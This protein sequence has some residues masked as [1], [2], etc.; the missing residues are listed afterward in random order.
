MEVLLIVLG[1]VLGIAGG[2]ASQFIDSLLRRKNRR[3]EY[4]AE[5]EI[6]ACVWIYPQFKWI[7]L[8][9]DKENPDFQSAEKVITDNNE[10]FWD[11]RLLLP[12]GV[13]EA[14]IYCRGAVHKR[15]KEG[16]MHQAQIAFPLLCKRFDIKE[17]P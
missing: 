6:D 17:F 12:P 11:N 8:Y 15:D 13:P 10:R 1:A 5:R 9:L 4:I 2:V 14:W 7:M 16:A 3:N